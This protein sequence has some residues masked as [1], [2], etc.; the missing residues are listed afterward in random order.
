MSVALIPEELLRA[1]LA[2]HRADRSAFEA[3]VRTR[4][5]QAEEGRESG[6]HLSPMLRAVASLLP[7]GFLKPAA[8]GGAA[9][10]APA[11]G[12]SKLIGYAAF[13]AISLFLLVG[14]AAFSVFA[15]R[16]TRNETGAPERDAA[17]SQAAAFQWWRD[18]RWGAKLVFAGS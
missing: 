10:M 1:A 11:T 18:H 2:P 13:P 7:A 6:A 14:A 8:L 9:K 12:A 15:I 3:G 5:A 16:K 17:A 4:L